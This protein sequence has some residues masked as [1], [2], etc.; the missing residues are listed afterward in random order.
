MLIDSFTNYQ[1]QTIGFQFLWLLLQ[2]PEFARIDLRPWATTNSQPPQRIKD[3]LLEIWKAPPCVPAY[4]ESPLSACGRATDSK[5]QHWGNATFKKRPKSFRPWPTER[6]CKV[7]GKMHLDALPWIPLLMRGCGLLSD[8]G[9]GI[10]NLARDSTLTFSH[11]CVAAHLA[12]TQHT[13][14]SNR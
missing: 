2:F 6:L 7:C 8:N 1:I 12:P 5:H 4:I 11:L 14:Y 3:E 13:S 9:I 10:D